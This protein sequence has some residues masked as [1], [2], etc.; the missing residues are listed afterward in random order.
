[1]PKH[2][3][4][5]LVGALAIASNAVAE[6]T[7]PATTTQLPPEL[8]TEGVTASPLTTITSKLA[9]IYL[10]RLAIGETPATQV[11]EGVITEAK[12]YSAAYSDADRTNLNDKLKAAALAYVNFV[13]EKAKASTTWPP[14]R[15]QDTY[16]GI[17]VVTLSIIEDEI[18]A[19]TNPDTDL[20]GPL[21]RANR[22]LA[23]STGLA[24]V[25]PELDHF[26]K[27]QIVV[28]YALG[29]VTAIEQ[30]KRPAE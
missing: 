11:A 13:T 28:E 5:L 14:D 2:L 19:P 9:T 27:H 21:S 18:N 7:P 10:V 24:E 4:A 30:P 12:A 26:A 22:V 6:E 3:I 16:I 20:V 17:A 25:S 8:T 1:M 29:R 23:W 15:P